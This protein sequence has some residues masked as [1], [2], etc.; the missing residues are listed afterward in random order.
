MIADLK[1]EVKQNESRA[2]SYFEKFAKL[3]GDYHNLIGIAAEL[4]DSLE[5]CVRGKMVKLYYVMKTKNQHLLRLRILMKTRNTLLTRLYFSIIHDIT[6]INRFGIT[7]ILFSLNCVPVTNVNSPSLHV[8][9]FY[10]CLPDSLTKKHSI[11]NRL[12]STITCTIFMCCP[13]TS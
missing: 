13:Q 6:V 1:E 12:K 3:Q 11:P 5:Q 2:N 10:Y 4:V 8:L 9:L 7:A